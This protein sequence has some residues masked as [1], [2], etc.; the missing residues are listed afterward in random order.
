M[1]K[2]IISV[3]LVLIA[4]VAFGSVVYAAETVTIGGFDFNVP[5]GFTEDKSH[6][7]VNMEK[8]QGGIKYINNGKLFENDKGDVVNILVAK[9]D[10][11]KVT[12]KIAKGIADEPKTI[13][14]VDGDI[15]HN[16]TFTSFDYAK[17]DKLLVITTIMKMQLKDLL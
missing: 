3:L 2:K 16:G 11:H 10:G 8:E 15:V 5:D 1:N 12:N 14:G 9:Y 13:G 6:A 17:E 4:A 7:I